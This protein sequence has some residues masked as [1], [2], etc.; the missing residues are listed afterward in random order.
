MLEKFD[1][2][3][4][5]INDLMGKVLSFLMIL[6]IL[7]VFY[8]VVVRYC[9]DGGSI[10]MQELQWHLFGVIIL[11]GMGYTLRKE[12]HVRVDFLYVTFSSK[13]K[14]IINVGGTILFIIPLAIFIIY[15]SYDFVMDSYNIN[16][17]SEDPGGLAYRWI[18]KSMIPI[19]FL[20]LILT[21]IGYIIH[22]FYK[23]FSQ[24]SK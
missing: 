16:E 19:S 4:E 12:G 1:K 15:G 24:Y 8:N 6:L 23:Y 22:Q 5:F 18:I 17:I 3:F 11:F 21:C 14:L 2:L 7:N 13:I 9:F 20:Y 10:A